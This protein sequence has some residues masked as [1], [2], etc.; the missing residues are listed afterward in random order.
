MVC[1]LDSRGFRHFRGFRDLCEFSTQLLVCSCASCLCHFRCFRDFRRLRARRRKQ[2]IALANHRFRNT[3]NPG[4][5]SRLTRRKCLF[6]RFRRRTHKFSLSG[7][8]AGWDRVNRTLNRANRLCLCAFF[9]RIGNGV[10]KQGCGNHPP[11]DD[12]N[13]IRKFSIDPLCL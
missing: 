11:I 10:G 4:T 2:A 13:P 5:A 3:R 1:T 9:L 12:R 8:L 7:Q 6:S